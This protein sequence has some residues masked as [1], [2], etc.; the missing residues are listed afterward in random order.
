MKLVIQIPAFNEEAT[1]E[2]ALAVLPR[3]VAGFAETRLL[4][5]DDGS[6]DATAEKARTAGADRIV[7]LST[8]RGLAEAFSVGLAEALAMGAD[9][10]VNFDADLQYDAS[11][12]PALV[13]PILEGRADFVVGRPG[14]RRARALLA[15]QAPAPEDRHV[16]RPASRRNRDR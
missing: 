5:V 6:T 9:V 15:G 1:M 13:R 14:S 2:K 16:G 4:V 3:R 7:R 10:V 11:D 8:N 12:I